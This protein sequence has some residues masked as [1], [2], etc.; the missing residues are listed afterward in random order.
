MQDVIQDFLVGGVAV[1]TLDGITE[2]SFSSGIVKDKLQNTSDAFIL[3]ESKHFI[4]EGD[5]YDTAYLI[6]LQSFLL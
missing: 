2:T 6:S 4:I 3:P 5:E 1:P